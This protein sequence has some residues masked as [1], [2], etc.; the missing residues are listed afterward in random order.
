MEGDDRPDDGCDEEVARLLLD[1]GQ[2]RLS[3]REL[4]YRG[5]A[6]GLSVPVLGWLLTSLDDRDPPPT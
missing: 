4:L 3:R 2:G 5:I 6:L 1:V